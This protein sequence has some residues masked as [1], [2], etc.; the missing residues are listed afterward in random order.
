MDRICQ[1]H[2]D[3][4][5]AANARISHRA[6]ATQAVEGAGPEAARR[7][8]SLKRDKEAQRRDV[9]VV[10][11]LPRYGASLPACATT[12]HIYLS[13]HCTRSLVSPEEYTHS[14]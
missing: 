13:P 11:P 10:G 4:H 9:T 14:R 7:T 2:P 6:T 12:P 5:V 1:Q 3:P 8:E